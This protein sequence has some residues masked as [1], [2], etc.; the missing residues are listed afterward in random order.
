MSETAILERIG[1]LANEAREWQYETEQIH[2]LEMTL[3]QAFVKGGY[4][5]KDFAPALAA[6]HEKSFKLNEK[7]NKT[8]EEALAFVEQNK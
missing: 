6:I 5:V 7:M 2:A 1:N 3:T 8:I 4:D